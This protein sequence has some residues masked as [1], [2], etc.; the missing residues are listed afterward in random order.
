VFLLLFLP[1]A[2]SEALKFDDKFRMKKSIIFIIVAH[3]IYFLGFIFG[4]TINRLK[5]SSF[6]QYAP[7]GL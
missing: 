7:P 2:L 5:C 4:A 1:L 6:V 3:I